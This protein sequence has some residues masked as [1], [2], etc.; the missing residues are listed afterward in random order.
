[1]K[2]WCLLLLIGIF[3]VFACSTVLAETGLEVE[4]VNKEN[5]VVA[6]IGNSA[7]YDLKINNL[8]GEDQFMVFTLVGVQIEP[9]DY[10]NLSSGNTTVPI[11]SLFIPFFRVSNKRNEQRYFQEQAAC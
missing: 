6:E 2:I 5:V 10:F 7:Y 1:M 9:R 8:D 3:A 11:I 4:E